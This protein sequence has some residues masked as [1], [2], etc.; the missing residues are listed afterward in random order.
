V[1]R[2]A[3]PDAFYLTISKT[4]NPILAVREGIPHPDIAKENEEEVLFKE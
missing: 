2:Y 1:G 3:R 4:P